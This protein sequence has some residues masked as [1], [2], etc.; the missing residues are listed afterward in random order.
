MGNFGS[1]L[2]GSG[3]LVVLGGVGFLTLTCL[4]ERFFGCGGSP[5]F[6][7]EGGLPPGGEETLRVDLP[8]SGQKD[9][10]LLEDTQV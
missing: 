10:I 7:L 4:M 1:S 3:G 6:V 8:H 9:R 2:G 5:G